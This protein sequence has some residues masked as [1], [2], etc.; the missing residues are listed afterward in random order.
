MSHVD[1]NINKLNGKYGSDY[2]KDKEA[3]MSLVKTIVI[4]YSSFISS[5]K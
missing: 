4:F 2:T 5:I 1:N 3:I